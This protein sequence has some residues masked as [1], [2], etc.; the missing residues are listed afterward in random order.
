MTLICFVYKSR[1]GRQ[2]LGE[3]RLMIMNLI[4]T[5]DFP[6]TGNAVVLARMRSGGTNPRIAWIPPGTDAGGERFRR[7]QEQ[8]AWYGFDRLDYCGI[9]AEADE[10]RLAQLD[11]Y[12]ILYLSG[13]DPIRFRRTMLHTGLSEQVRQC[14]AAG[15]LVVAASGGSL[16]LTQNVSLFRLQGAGIDDVVARRSEDQALSVVAYELLP[17]L[18]RCEPAF[19]DKVRQYSERVD[20]DI[21][22]LADGAAVLHNSRD[23]YHCVGQAAIFRQGVMTPLNV[24]A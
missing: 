15:R 8:F 20:C 7:A 1:F 14:L 5:S 19:L 4:L 3:G 22:A 6:S 11:Q 18:N 9:E 2:T 13:G 24:A 17:H 16:Q 10:H 23:D 12:D 21:V